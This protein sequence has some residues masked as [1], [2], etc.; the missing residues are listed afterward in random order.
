MSDLLP[1]L[2]GDLDMMPSPVPGRPG[3]LMRDPFHYSDSVLIV[4]PALVE[5]LRLFDGES[6]ET[7][8][9]ALLVRLS[10]DIRVGDM[11]HG[12]VKTLSEAG[13]VHDEVYERMKAGR[14][15]AF[16]N[17]PERTP[18]LAGAAYPA[19]AG[20]TAALIS[21]Y[22]N[23]SKPRSGLVGIAAPH[24]SLD[25]GAECYAAAYGALG[26]ELR[27]RTFV[28]IGTSHYGGP[29]RFGL[30]RKPFVTPL[31]TARTAADLVD[32]L[33]RFGGPAVKM[34]DYCHAVEH[35]I[36]FQV[37]F[38]QHLFGPEV[39]ILPVLCGP[40]VHSIFEGGL[41][42]ETEAVGRFLEALRQMGEREASRLFW[43]LGVDMAHMGRRYG[44]PHAVAAN[45]GIM[46]G[47]AAED[48]RRIELIA[49]GDAPGFWTAVAADQDPLRWCGAAPIYTFL[50]AAP[51]ARGELLG[52]RQWNIDE[53]SVVSFAALAF[54]KR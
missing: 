41:P 46:T 28:I 12:F 30:T 20:G 40:F 13:F 3:L 35:S 48:K 52:Y 1:R 24:V 17:A 37:L 21:G 53:Q 27:D 32:E 16:A 19:D 7:D 45:R 29:E 23:G 15:S 39:R 18:A 33:E 4:P 26:P 22:M 10:G 51:G 8:L 50:K 25:G 31:G 44:D 34:E 5:C 43:V 14:E 9:R 47:V 11:L 6:T 49:A 2:R 42:E 36:E 54:S 38:L